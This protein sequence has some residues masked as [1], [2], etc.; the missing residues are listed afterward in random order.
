MYV[1]TSICF[2]HCTVSV[3][4][5][6]EAGYIAKSSITLLALSTKVLL[7]AFLVHG[8]LLSGFANIGWENMYRDITQASG[9]KTVASKG[10]PSS[11][12]GMGTRTSMPKYTTK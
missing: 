10:K 9:V 4:P 12:T 1:H 3:K 5:I 7:E 11:E 2:V 8:S 6:L